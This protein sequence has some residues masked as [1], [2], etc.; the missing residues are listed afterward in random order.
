M[1]VCIYIRDI[2]FDQ[3]IKIIIRFQQ[4]EGR[5]KTDDTIIIK[6]LFRNH[7]LIANLQCIP[8]A[9]HYVL[10]R[11]DLHRKRFKADALAGL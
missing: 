3:K 7:K 9:F 2:D 1:C 11:Q 6:I 8:R 4:L 5:I 10:P